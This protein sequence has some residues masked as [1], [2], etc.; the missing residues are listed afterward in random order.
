MEAETR[1]TE[2][3][4]ATRKGHISEDLHRQAKKADSPVVN[5]ILIAARKGF[6]RHVLEVLG[7]KEG[8]AGYATVTDK[9]CR[10][11]TLQRA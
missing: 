8:G 7:R 5:E 2:I 4:K 10:N 6:T 1:A 11:H 3:S 9:V